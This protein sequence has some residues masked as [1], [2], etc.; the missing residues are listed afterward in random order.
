MAKSMPRSA[1]SSSTP[2]TCDPSKKGLS[3]TVFWI[4]S[5]ALA[6][7]GL[8]MLIVPMPVPLPARLAAG[9]S[10]LIGA[11]V[12]GVLAWQKQNPKKAP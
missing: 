6:L 11:A 3:P 1:A 10:D 8:M 7:I 2:V 4:I 5:G 9:A 12:F